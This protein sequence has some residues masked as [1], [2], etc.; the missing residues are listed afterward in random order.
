[1]IFIPHIVIN[2]SK[3]VKNNIFPA[4]FHDY[5]DKTVKNHYTL[6]C[7]GKNITNL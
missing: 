1:M 2:T 6:R 3:T 4:C 5:V 7:Y